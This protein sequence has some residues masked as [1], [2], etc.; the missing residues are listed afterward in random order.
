MNG[1]TLFFVI[2]GVAVVTNLLFKLIDI[3]ESDI[4]IKD[5]LKYTIRRIKHIA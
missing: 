5:L 2:I 1:W 3:I 4:S